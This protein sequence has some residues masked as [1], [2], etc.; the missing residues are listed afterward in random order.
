MRILILTV[1]FGVR[2]SSLFNPQLSH[3]L[4]HSYPLRTQL[5]FLLKKLI[6]LLL[7]KRVVI[8]IMKKRFFLVFSFSVVGRGHWLHRLRRKVVRIV[9]ITLHHSQK[10]T[11]DGLTTS[12]QRHSLVFYKFFVPSSII[13]KKTR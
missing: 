2:F 12:K 8:I 4:L 13:L 10:I 9:R 3:S 7:K 11:D 6:I 1:F 5:F